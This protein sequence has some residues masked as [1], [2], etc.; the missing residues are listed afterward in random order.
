MYIQDSIAFWAR[1]EPSRPAVA[2]GNTVLRSYGELHARSIGLAAWLVSA[3]VDL[4]RGDR[5]V[6][7]VL[8]SVEFFES[9]FACWQA[10]A[11]A[12]PLNTC[13]LYTSPSPR[14]A[15]LSRMPSSA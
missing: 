3:G 12:V 5:V 2:V 15:T 6:I 4:R 1:H 14:D 8:N 13:L 10:G 7:L 11:I 9:L